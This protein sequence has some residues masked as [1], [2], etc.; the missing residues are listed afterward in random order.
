MV[1]DIWQYI[2]MSL[3]V[4]EIIFRLL[5]DVKI[6]KLLL[7]N[8]E[9]KYCTNFK[10]A[11]SYKNFRRIMMYDNMQRRENF[12]NINCHIN[13]RRKILLVDVR[14]ERIPSTL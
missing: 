5:F 11:P 7:H 3:E 12:I 8:D 13:R 4:Y 2:F 1:V 14:R 9:Y 6:L 10:T